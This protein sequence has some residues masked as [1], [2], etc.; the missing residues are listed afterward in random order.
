MPRFVLLSH[1]FP[2]QHWDL[3]LEAGSSLRTWRLPAML[4]LGCDLPIEALPDH[5][6]AYLDYEGPVSGGRGMVSRCDAGRFEWLADAPDRV[7]VRLRGKD[8]AGV[9]VIAR[10]ADVRWRL[11]FES[12]HHAE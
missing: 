7:V 4:S 3:M 1:D 6:L 10:E 12:V 11:T 8:L 5:R 2:K 9:V